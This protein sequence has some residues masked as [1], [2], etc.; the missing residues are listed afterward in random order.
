MTPEVVRIIFNMNPRLEP[1][2]KGGWGDL[3]MR[4]PGEGVMGR[5]QPLTVSPLSSIFAGLSSDS[6]TQ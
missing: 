5:R 6:G 4:R 2:E 3:E 1:L